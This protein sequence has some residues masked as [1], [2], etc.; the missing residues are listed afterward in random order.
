[1]FGIKT[2]NSI[3]LYMKV[4]LLAAP[5]RL[6]FIH[7][8]APRDFRFG[9]F[10]RRLSRFVCLAS[11]NGAIKNGPDYNYYV[12]Y[13]W[14]LDVFGCRWLEVHV[15][16]KFIISAHATAIF[17][18]FRVFEDKGQPRTALLSCV[19]PAF[20]FF[21]S[22]LWF[23]FNLFHS[24]D[25]RFASSVTRMETRANFKFSKRAMKTQ[26]NLQWTLQ[27]AHTQTHVRSIF[28]RMDSFW[29]NS[30]RFRIIDRKSNCR[31]LRNEE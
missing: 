2:W 30:R 20:S 3:A 31:R 11:L 6:N 26:N 29:S 14:L 8:F 5:H 15:S 24:V 18:V 12:V 16:L 22:F 28:E 21:L 10:L 9:A 17:R 27:F 13:G 23:A 25:V 19:D 1:M 4:K 7:S